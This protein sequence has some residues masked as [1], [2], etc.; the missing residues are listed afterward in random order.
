MPKFDKILI[1]GANGVLGREFRRLFT[2]LL[3]DKQVLFTDRDKSN[4]TI[5]LD[6]SNPN[7]VI[8]LVGDYR[9]DCIINL[10]AMTDVDRCELEPEL[11]MRINVD[12]VRHLAAVSCDYGIRLVHISSGQVFNG[13]K[14]TPYLENDVPDPVNIYGKTK[15]NSEKI[16]REEVSQGYIIRTSWLIGGDRNED[17]FVAKLIRRMLVEPEISVVN[18]KDGSPTFAAD[19]APAIWQVIRHWPPGTYHLVN[20]GAAT[21]YQMAIAIRCA[22]GL[23]TRIRPGSSDTIHLPAE[24]PDHEILSSLYQGSP[25]FPELP[26]WEESLNHYLGIWRNQA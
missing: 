23:T 17:K 20:R 10:A 24:R 18:D 6:I 11:A 19:L 5:Q 9:P 7:E 14:K 26:D 22:L 25:G 1:T 2:G 15:C 13:Q 16:V 21:R 8:H 12:G 4:G 3:D